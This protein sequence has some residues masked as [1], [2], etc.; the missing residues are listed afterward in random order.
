MTTNEARALVDAHEMR[1]RTLRQLD[2]LCRQP[3]SPN[4]P[5]MAGHERNIAEAG[6][7][8][9]AAQAQLDQLLAAI[10]TPA[11]VAQP[12]DPPRVKGT[13][14]TRDTAAA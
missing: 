11:P 5:E 12:A 14:I 7:R 13:E 10:P 6:E 2:N 9:A 1:D 4:N 3:V 8:Y